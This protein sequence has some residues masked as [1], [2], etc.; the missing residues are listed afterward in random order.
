VSPFKKFSKII[1]SHLIDYFR[2]T[3]MHILTYGSPTEG[4]K[5]KEEEEEE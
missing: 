5:E 3:N 2:Y 4:V 1:D